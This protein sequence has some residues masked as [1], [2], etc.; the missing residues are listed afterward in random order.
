MNAMDP[1]F[2]SEARTQLVAGLYRAL[3]HREPDAEGLATYTNALRNG[4]SLEALLSSFLQSQEF[5]TK[6]PN[7]INLYPLDGAPSIA[8]GIDISAAERRNLWKKVADAWST[9]GEQDPYWSVLTH[10]QYPYGSDG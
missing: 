8:V 9:L 4:L 5:Q 3:L 10:D 2:S 7:L 6:L 1:G